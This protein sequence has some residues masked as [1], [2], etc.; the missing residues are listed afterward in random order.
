V[1]NETQT[2]VSKAFL[3]T[4]AGY[5]LAGVPIL[6]WAHAA[7]DACIY[8]RALDAIASGVAFTTLG[9][10]MWWLRDPERERRPGRSG[11]RVHKGGKK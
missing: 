5:L 11:R 4:G 8:H 9:G 1:S 3:L 7:G 6:V 10:V 2:F